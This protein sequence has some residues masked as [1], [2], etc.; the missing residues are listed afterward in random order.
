MQKQKRY[1]KSPSICKKLMPNTSKAI[2]LQKKKIEILKKI[3]LF[4]PQKA[5]VLK[6]K[7]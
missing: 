6:R 5:N 1:Y 4:I 3:N 2:S 7:Q